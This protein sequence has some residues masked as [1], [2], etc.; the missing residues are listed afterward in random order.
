MT[1]DEH[2]YTGT[3]AIFGHPCHWLHLLYAGECGE[4]D[5]TVVCNGSDAMEVYFYNV[6]EDERK[7]IVKKGFRLIVQDRSRRK[8]ESKINAI[9]RVEWRGSGDGSEDEC[10]AEFSWVKGGAERIEKND[11]EGK[12]EEEEGEVDGEGN[13][14]GGKG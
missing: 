8:T 10:V 14:V 1:N 3:Q 4:E 11:D 7:L 6:R 12:D 5:S 9:V 13:G 2:I